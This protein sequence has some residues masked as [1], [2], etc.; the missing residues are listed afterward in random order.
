[1]PTDQQEAGLFNINIVVEF[2]QVNCGTATFR[3]DPPLLVLV[4]IELLL[5]YTVLNVLAFIAEFSKAGTKDRVFEL[6]SPAPGTSTL[7][8]IAIMTLYRAYTRICDP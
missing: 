8:S 5:F 3:V 1:M 7:L 4:D 6:V 2:H